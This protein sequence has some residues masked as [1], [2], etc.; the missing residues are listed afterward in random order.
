MTQHYEAPLTPEEHY[1][2]FESLELLTTTLGLET[3]P[4]IGERGL[5]GDDEMP[6]V[7]AAYELILDVDGTSS[8]RETFGDLHPDERL[9]DATARYN[10][11]VNSDPKPI[12]S[13]TTISEASNGLEYTRVFDIT[14][15][16]EP[17]LFDASVETTVAASSSALPPGAAVEASAPMTARQA[18]LVRTLA[19][20]VLLDSDFDN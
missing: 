7:E 8:L 15:E 16:E 6:T 20:L 9:L 13:L 4:E 11:Y 2:T 14:A 17:E 3:E 12:A 10:S 1:I 19:A 5:Y 18:R